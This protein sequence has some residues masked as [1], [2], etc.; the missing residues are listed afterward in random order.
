[1]RNV[2]LFALV[3]L[4]AGAIVGCGGTDPAPSAPGPAGQAPASAGTQAPAPTPASAAPAPAPTLETEPDYIAVD[5]IL[6]GVSGRLPG[7]TRK[8]EEARKIAYEVL[9]RAR[10]G[11][12]WA[13]LKS[14]HSDDPPPGGPYNMANRGVAPR[15]PQP[16]E[17]ERDGMVPAF[18]DVG[19]RLPRG[20]IGLAEYDPQ[21]SPF[22]FHL[23]RR[24]DVRVSHILVPW[25][26]LRNAPGNVQRTKEEARTIAGILRDRARKGED[27][28]MLARENST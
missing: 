11:E 12:D 25:A 28:A 19:F 22:G 6:I 13:T 7:C 2:W 18:G 20:A 15:A 24:V 14:R 10:K 1:M 8:P 3:I 5:H 23:I 4:S 21:K 9:D 27:F 17:F 16:R 26:G